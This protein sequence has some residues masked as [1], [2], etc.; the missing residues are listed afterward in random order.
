ME[1]TKYGPK[2]DLE[3]NHKNEQKIKLLEERINNLESRLVPVSAPETDD[4]LQENLSYDEVMNFFIDAIKDENYKKF[5]SRKKW[6]N[7]IDEITYLDMSSD[8]LTKVT[9]NTY[10]SYTTRRD[11]LMANDWII[12]DGWWELSAYKEMRK[13]DNE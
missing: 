13:I 3:A 8:N 12:F 9:H 6:I 5:A 7:E 10:E 4:N 11:D 1:N 2:G